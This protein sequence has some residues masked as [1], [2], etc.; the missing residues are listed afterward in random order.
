LYLRATAE[1]RQ[2]VA[3]SLGWP[4][5]LPPASIPAAH[6]DKRQPRRGARRRD[7]IRARRAPPR[8]SQRRLADG[9][10]APSTAA[11]L[12]YIAR[13]DGSYAYTHEDATNNLFSGT[14][15]DD[16]PPSAR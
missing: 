6:R 16:D 12:G 11:E 7:P 9:H 5:R 10:V 3:Q 14:S 8:Q 2:T 1:L 15:R 13:P 4:S